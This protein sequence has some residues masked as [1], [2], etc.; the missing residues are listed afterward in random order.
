M[1]NKELFQRRNLRPTHD[2]SRDISPRATTYYYFLGIL[3]ALFSVYFSLYKISLFKIKFLESKVLS[4]LK[5]TLGGKE[6][7]IFQ[8]YLK[9]VLHGLTFSTHSY[10][11]LNENKRFV[12][13]MTQKVRA[14]CGV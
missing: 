11:L 10:F 3:F 9:K 6:M 14:L 12:F 13:L 7:T 1:G 5:T 2:R 4:S 8:N